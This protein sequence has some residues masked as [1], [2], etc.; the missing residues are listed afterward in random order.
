MPK[1]MFLELLKY[2]EICRFGV[3]NVKL[4]KIWPCHFSRLKKSWLEP[5][6]EVCSSKNKKF[7]TTMQSPE[8]LEDSPFNPSKAWNHKQKQM[9]QTKSILFTRIN[10]IYW[11]TKSQQEFNS[12]FVCIQISI[13]RLLLSKTSKIW[14]T[15]TLATSMNV[16]FK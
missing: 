5:K 2:A 8:G 13:L 7:G 4:G 14:I 9:I 10:R 3:Q 6:F 15:Y 16:F 12:T 11:I 1:K